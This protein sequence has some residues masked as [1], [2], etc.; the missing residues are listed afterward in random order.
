MIAAF[1]V[2]IVER[3]RIVPRGRSFDWPRD[4]RG[5]FGT[6]VCVEDS[7]GQLVDLAGWADRDPSRWFLRRGEAVILGASILRE[8]C[9]TGNPITLFGTPAD[10]FAAKGQ[11]VVIV[12]WDVD[13]RALF[14]CIE[15]VNCAVPGLAEKLRQSLARAPFRIR[16]SR[17][18]H[19]A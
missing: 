19:A 11:G 7:A 10:W 3:C 15:T 16:E 5:M 1:G 18:H 12:D 13:L 8:A 14:E 17:L 4:G 2:P 9:R 6:M